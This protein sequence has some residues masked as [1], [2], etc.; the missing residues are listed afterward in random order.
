MDRRKFLKG[1]LAA[2]G[3]LTLQPD[4]VLAAAQKEHV[5]AAQAADKIDCYCHFSGMKVIDYLEEPGG[6]KT[7]CLPEPLFQ[8]AYIDQ[9][10]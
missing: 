2:A 3:V 8:H 9:G 10:N 6:G 1:S 7:P 5:A 4:A